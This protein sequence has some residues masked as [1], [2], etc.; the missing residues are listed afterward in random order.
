[1]TDLRDALDR[2]HLFHDAAEAAL[3]RRLAA[4]PE[5]AP[6]WARL[7][8]VLRQR[9]DVAGAAEACR[10]VLA[11]DPDYAPAARLLAVLEGRGPAVGGTVPAPFVVVDGVLSEA[12]RALVWDTV[13]AHEAAFVDSKLEAGAFNAEYRSSRSIKKRDLGALVP[14][15]QAHV[16]DV[17]ARSWAALGVAPFE[18]GRI[19]MQLTAHLDGGFYKAHRDRGDVPPYAS[20]AVTYLYY[21]ARE[22]RRFE[23]GDLLL[24]DTD[25]EADTFGAAYT[26]V[27]HVDDRLVL[28][29]SPFY[30]QVTSVTSETGDLHDA[31]FA[32]NGWVHAPEG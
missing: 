3:R 2:S 15:V 23:G 5:S 17:L 21:F 31:R 13:D 30:H 32:I 8:D 10:R 14:V 7:A 26:R 24:L 1:M 11:L 28:F 25:L 6:T 22:P 19:E 29:P 12:E 9:G 18:P 16:L 4:D 27:R 20:R